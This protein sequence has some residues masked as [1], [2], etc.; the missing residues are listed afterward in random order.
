MT[1]GE[2]RAAEFERMRPRLFG[3]AY[4]MTG[5]R[6]DAEDAVQETWLRYA[7]TDAPVRS[8]D[9]F[10]VTTLTRLCID[11][12]RSGR[13]R[14]EEYVGPWLPEPLLT[15]H[16]DP[17]ADLERFELLSTALLRV[18]EHLDPLERAVFLLREVFGYPYADIAAMVERR[19]D[20]CR[21]LAHRAKRRLRSERPGAEAR[22]EEHGR[23][24]EGFLRASVAGDLAGL[25]ALLL[26]D[27]VLLSDSGGNA[28]AARRPVVGSN[29]VA[30][31][32]AGIAAKASP[33]ARIDRVEL[34]GLPGVLLH[35]RGRL[36]T[37]MSVDVRDGRIA[38]VFLW[39]N[40][41]KLVGLEG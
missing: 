31:F 34:N 36:Q 12:L 29:P 35:D 18:L 1:T 32:M 17:G 7:T 23:L 4:R 10:L 26:D 41:E 21:Q 28:P 14:R 6:A 27:V 19:E 40:P 3:I 8:V 25:E 11:Q 20:H 22:V 30:R 9:G 38:A 37:A 15:S 39:R 2:V 24:L 16:D 5:S 13:A 33:E